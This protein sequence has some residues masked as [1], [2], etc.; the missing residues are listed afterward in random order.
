MWTLQSLFPWLWS[1]GGT[2]PRCL[3]QKG[4]ERGGCHASASGRCEALW[5]GASCDENIF[6][7]VVV[8]KEELL[9]CTCL[10]VCCV[11]Q[12]WDI[13]RLLHPAWR[14][15]TV[16]SCVLSLGSCLVSFYGWGR[17]GN[18]SCRAARCVVQPQISPGYPS[19]RQGLWWAGTDYHSSWWSSNYLQFS[20]VSLGLVM[21]I[22]M[23][24]IQFICL[25]RL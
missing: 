8:G 14:W 16:F 25:Q 5:A 22:R 10:G 17:S 4:R 15:K 20:L 9:S 1:G 24:R 3:W 11:S 19:M 6:V 7:V 18:L 12:W 13:S 2:S 21:F 23:C